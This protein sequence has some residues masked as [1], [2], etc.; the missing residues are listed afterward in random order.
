M[1]ATR[2]TIVSPFKYENG[3]SLQ[4]DCCYPFQKTLKVKQRNWQLWNWFGNLTG[5]IMNRNLCRP[6]WVMGSVAIPRLI[7]SLT[8]VSIRFLPPLSHRQADHQSKRPQSNLRA[9]FLIQRPFNRQ[10]I[11]MFSM[12]NPIAVLTST[13]NWN[14]PPRPIS[15]NQTQ[16]RLEASFV[17]NCRIISC[18]NRT[19]LDKKKKKKK[20]KWWWW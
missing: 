20:K 11:S 7:R 16:I 18:T 1:T 13:A 3:P 4:F 10:S 2:A 6:Q 19:E 15:V 17:T 8:S 14:K 12:W 5:V 9:A